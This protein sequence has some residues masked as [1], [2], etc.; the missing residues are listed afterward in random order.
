MIYTENIMICISAPLLVTLLFLR[1]GMRRFVLAF[2]MGMLCCLLSGYLGGFFNLI[3][4]APAE[5]TAVFISPV[6]EEILKLLPL[7][8][9]I[10]VFEMGDR[11]LLPIAVAV[12]AGF[13]TFENCCFLLQNGAGS[14]LYTAIRGLGAGVMHVVAMLLLRAGIFIAQR[15]RVLSA[16]TITGALTLSVVFHGL[17]NL[18]AAERGFAA[19]I[20][21]CM[22]LAVAAF[23]YYIHRA[24]LMPEKTPEA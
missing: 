8:F 2:L 5:E 22:P 4:G 13:A 23:Y 14:I 7:L 9:C 20:G 21:Y 3:S 1:G 17:Y 18:L 12:G 24:F 15:Y 10:A 11:L 6:I 16:A 19:Y